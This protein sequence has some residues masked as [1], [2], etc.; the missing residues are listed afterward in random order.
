VSETEQKAEIETEA[1]PAPVIKLTDNVEKRYLVFLEGL[2]APVPAV[3]KRDVRT[4]VDSLLQAR[5]P[6]SGKKGNHGLFV[7]DTGAWNADD[8][9]GVSYDLMGDD[10]G[11]DE[12]YDD[13]GDE[14][15]PP[16]IDEETLVALQKL[17]L[18]GKKP[19]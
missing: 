6:S 2:T 10:E 5:M 4:V 12:D 1:A 7:L 17:S 8:V 11:E 15:E 3:D 9:V 13:E 16:E 19:S 18:G 14:G